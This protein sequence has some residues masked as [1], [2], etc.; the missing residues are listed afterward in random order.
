MMT[1]TTERLLNLAAAAPAA[2]GEDLVGLLREGNVLY[3]RGL[4]ES[5][6]LISERLGALPTDE[7]VVAAEAAGMP[8]TASADRG[9][10]LLLLALAEWQMTPAALAY[11]GMAEDAARRGVCLLPEE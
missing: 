4:Q 8:C 1:T 5:R 3:H 9:E 10:V 7:L 11:S 6:E 2:E